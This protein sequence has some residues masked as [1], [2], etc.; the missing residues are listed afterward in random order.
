M[1]TNNLSVLIPYRSDGGERDRIFDWIQSRY[2]QLL[3]E[4]EICIGE[5]DS[6]VFNRSKARNDA[7]AKSTKDYLLVADADTAVEP[8]AVGAALFLIMQQHR[9]WY[10]PYEWYYNINAEVS[11]QILR[12]S[13]SQSILIH[14]GQW[15][16]KLDST[17]GMLLMPRDA[18]ETVDGYDERFV[19]WGYEDNAFQLALDTLWAPHRRVGFGQG[20]HLH[21]PVGE[22]FDQP[23]IKQNEILFRRYKKA[24]GNVDLMKQVL[25]SKI[26]L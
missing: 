14:E 26:V 4:V 7:F 11:E 16:H 21:H 2:R 20:L 19:G 25:G 23:F 24:C 12:G 1:S 5:D 3:P 6:D 13:P 8:Y 18:W 10:I 22:R 17:A 9:S 15:D